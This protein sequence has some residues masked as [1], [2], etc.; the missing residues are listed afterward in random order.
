MN[1]HSSKQLNIAFVAGVLDSSGSFMICKN[2]VRVKGVLI[3]HRYFP[4][5]GIN[6]ANT[7]FLEFIKNTFNFGKVERANRRSY[8]PKHIDGKMYRFRLVNSAQVK[9]L[10]QSIMP[11][12][13]NKKK[14]A[15]ILLKICST[16]RISNNNRKKIDES[17]QSERKQYYDEIKEL[18]TIIP[19]SIILKITSNMTNCR[20]KNKENNG[21]IQ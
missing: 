11:Y 12:L 20:L 4:E 15:Q 5:I 17:V 9:E 1:N 14:H 10:I 7:A 16:I 13:I 2:Q 18:N 6:N 19:R 3:S 8:N 21:I